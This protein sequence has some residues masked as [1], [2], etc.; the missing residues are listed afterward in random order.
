MSHDNDA[1]CNS[2]ELRRLS[3]CREN[4]RCVSSYSGRTKAWSGVEQEVVNQMLPVPLPTKYNVKVHI[5]LGIVLSPYPYGDPNKYFMHNTI[6]LVAPT[7]CTTT[8]FNSHHSTQQ[9]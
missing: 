2:F 8:G 1:M 7:K 4:N 5:Y 3:S 9:E 6:L